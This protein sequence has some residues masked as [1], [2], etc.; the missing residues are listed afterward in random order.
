MKDKTRFVARITAS[1]LEPADGE[2][3]VHSYLKALNDDH[4]S[5]QIDNTKAG[6]SGSDAE[7]F[8]LIVKFTRQ[9]PPSY[10]LR[11]QPRKGGER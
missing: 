5:S 2:Y 8:T 10:A 4:I 7:E 11:L 3:L 9:P 1:G 6:P